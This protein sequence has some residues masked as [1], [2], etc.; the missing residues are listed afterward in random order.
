LDKIF[1]GSVTEK[2]MQLTK[3][4]LLIIPTGTGK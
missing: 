2:V 1:M 3:V 4:P